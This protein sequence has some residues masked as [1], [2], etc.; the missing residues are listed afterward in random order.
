MAV[1]NNNWSS[2]TVTSTEGDTRD[3]TALVAGAVETGVA[4]AGPTKDEPV[5]YALVP[6]GMS[7]ESLE[8]YQ[9]PDG[10]PKERIAGAVRLYDTASFTKYVEA[11]TDERTRVF[12][13]PRSCSFLGVLDY[14]VAGERKPEFLAHK[15]HL[16]LEFDDRW[17][18]WTAKDG[19]WFSQTDFAEFIEDNYKDIDTPPAAAM[20]EVAR[21]LHAKNE[22]NFDSKVSLKDG[23][24]QMTYTENLKAGIGTGN[25]EVPDT[26][27]IRIPVFYGEHAVVLDVRLRFRITNQKLVFCYKMYR[28]QETLQ[29]AFRTAVDSIAAELSTDVLMG[30]PV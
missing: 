29:N 7:I 25:M 13:D 10:R 16:T 20:L 28:R 1:L 21:D 14:H 2:R 6:T 8:D 18:I 15:A 12:A 24:I 3:L 4:L 26:F 23:H 11:F 9:F 17:K 27:T 22:V 19:A 30:M 5:H